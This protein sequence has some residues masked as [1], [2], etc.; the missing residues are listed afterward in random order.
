MTV[1]LPSREISTLLEKRI[2]KSLIKFNK[3]NKKKIPYLGE[4]N[5][6]HQPMWGSTPPLQK[7]DIGVLVKT[8]F[9]MIQKSALVTKNVNDIL[10]CIRQCCQQIKGIDPSPLISTGKATL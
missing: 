1:V 5:S 9:N 2:D 3:N 6:W 10:G 4:K 8:K 7:K